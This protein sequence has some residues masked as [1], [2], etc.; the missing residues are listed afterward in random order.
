MALAPFVVQQCPVAAYDL[1]EVSSRT[2]QPHD[3]TRVSWE[4]GGMQFN[5]T[6]QMA[7]SPAAAQD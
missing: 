1:C 7:G 6:K 5:H 2:V 3:P 4:T